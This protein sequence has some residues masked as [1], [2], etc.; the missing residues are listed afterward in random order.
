M[1]LEDNGV[2]VIVAAHNAQRTIRRAVRSALEQ[3]HVCEVIVVDDASRD[4]T[5]GEARLEDDGSGRLAVVALA[6]NGGPS[7]ARNVALDRAKAPHVCVLDS[8]DYFLPGRIASLLSADMGPWDMLADDIVIVPEEA[9]A[10]FSI[11]SVDGP[12]VGI[13]LDLATF[14]D[15]NISRRKRLRGEMGFLKPII[16]REFLRRHALRYDEQLRLGEDYALY[17][18]ALMAGARFCVVGARGYVA[19]QRQGS[20]SAQHSAQDLERMARFDA[21]CLADGRGLDEREQAA[22]AAHRRAMLL[23]FR[24]RSVLDTK[25][26]RGLLAA[27]GMLASHPCSLPFIAS[28][29]V[30]AKMEAARQ[31]LGLGNAGRS[32]RG[33][34][35]RLLLGLPQARLSVVTP[36]VGDA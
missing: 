3:E 28:E 16:R 24:Y 4:D 7:H 29:T 32:D 8:D 20:I 26:T 34:Q 25:N 19:T 13:V 21:Q 30:S 9:D 31:A 2:A 1:T 10:Q 12:P 33:D 27:V 6:E 14:V 5:C 36:G 22:L 17:T 23:K 35:I 18:R 11:G 15:G